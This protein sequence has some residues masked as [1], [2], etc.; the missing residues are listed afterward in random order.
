[1]KMQVTFLSVLFNLNGEAT[2]GRTFYHETK[3]SPTGWVWLI[4]Y[5]HEKQYMVPSCLRFEGKHDCLAFLQKGGNSS[6]CFGNFLNHLPCDHGLHTEEPSPKCNTLMMDMGH[7][8]GRLWPLKDLKCGEQ[9]NLM[10]IIKT[11]LY[12]RF[13]PTSNLIWHICCCE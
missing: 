7:T 5:K 6:R 1:M 4:G 10:I 13:F 11:V 3:I 2:I 8:L 9:H 12:F